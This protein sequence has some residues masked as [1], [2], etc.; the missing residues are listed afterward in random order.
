METFKTTT[1]QYSTIHDVVKNKVASHSYEWPNIP[2]WPLVD[3]S[4]TCCNWFVSW[5]L[6]L[7]ACCGRSTL[8]R[9]A[10]L[11]IVNMGSALPGV[12]KITHFQLETNERKHGQKVPQHSSW[13][14]AAVGQLI[15]TW[16]YSS[17]WWTHYFMESCFGSAT[18][19][20]SFAQMS[21]CESSW[22]RLKNITIV[23]N[24]IG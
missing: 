14:P 7:A 15:S 8:L 11:G 13:V 12:C 20:S 3:N 22:T 5:V 9:C 1:C 2:P 4:S 6:A 23:H 16:Y 24:N 21:G 10:R 17:S 18:G 19:L